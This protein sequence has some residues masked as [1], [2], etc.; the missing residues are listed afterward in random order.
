MAIVNLY[1]LQ[2]AQGGALTYNTQYY[3]SFCDYGFAC[4]ISLDDEKY[5]SIDRG[6]KNALVAIGYH[7]VGFIVVADMEPGEQQFI[8][9]FS[10]LKG[11]THSRN[12]L[13]IQSKSNPA[14]AGFFYIIFLM[15]FPSIIK[16]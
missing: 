10:I 9:L 4:C 15:I 12:N 6:R 5:K 8:Y 13:I 7:L 3:Q 14:P 1:V 11:S 16:P 2:C